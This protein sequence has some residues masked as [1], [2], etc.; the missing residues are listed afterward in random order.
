MTGLLLSNRLMQRIALVW[1]LVCSAFFYY[2]SITNPHAEWDMLVYAAS[3]EVLNSTPYSEIHPKVYSELES[4]LSA[5]EFEKIARGDHY[6]SVMYEDADAFMEQLPYYRIRVTFNS[7]LAFAGKHGVSLYTAGHVISATAI[8]LCFLFIWF[9][10]RSHIHPVLQ[11]AMPLVFYKFTRELEVMQMILADSLASFWVAL[12]CY[13]YVK[14]SNVLL[15]LIA[16]SVLVRVDLFI[17]AALM[18]M[19]LLLTEKI[20]K[21]GPVI[22]CGCIVASIFL[23]IQQWADSYGWKTLY[24]F[25]IISEMSATH[26]SEYSSAALSFSDY[27]YSLFFPPRWISKMYL[28]TVFCSAVTLYMWKRNPDINDFQRRVCEVGGICL[29]Y[30]AAHYLIF[31]Q[32]YLRFFVAQNMIIFTAFA[33]LVSGYLRFP[34]AVPGS[35]R[36]YPYA[37]HD[38]RLSER[39]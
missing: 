22:L 9:A 29:L 13:A 18:L 21:W 35:L 7:L 19:L 32:L 39:R 5:G 16:V 27:V 28:V 33:I 34:I 20:H 8:I 25:A 2:S 38:S 24:Y 15:P 3:A 14:K 1:V 11:M 6:R 23:A 17:F 10:F 26:P 30:I 36:Q 31:P 12:I 4:R 37:S